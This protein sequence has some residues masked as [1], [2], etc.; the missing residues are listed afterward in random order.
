LIHIQKAAAE[1][2]CGVLGGRSLTMLLDAP[3]AARLEGW[4]HAAFLDV[5]YGSLR[6]LGELRACLAELLRRPLQPGVVESLLLVA[7]YQ[8]RYSRAAAHAVVD[9]A[10][11]C[12]AAIGAP[13]AKGLV[14]AVLRAFLMDPDGIVARAHSTEEGKFSHPSWWI[15]KLR[16]QYPA[17]WSA[18]LAAGNEHPPLTLRVRVTRIS[19]E[20]YLDR[21]RADRIEARQTGVS[22][23]TLERPL[24]VAAVPGFA[25]GL[26]SVQDAGA[27]LAAPLLDLKDGMRVLDACAAPGGKSSHILDLARV[28]LL[29]LDRDEPRLQKVRGN[30]DRLGL[31]AEVVTGDAAAPATWWDGTPFHRILAD[32]PCSASGVVRR[33]PDVKWLRRP[34]DVLGFAANQL[35][36][37]D[38]LWHTLRR[39]GKLLY[40]TCSVFREENQDQADRFLS[41]HRD[42][43]RLPVAALPEDGMLLPNHDHDGFF[44]ALF[45]KD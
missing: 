17:A 16:L 21:L 10:V 34:A 42:A 24:P 8:L 9:H 2:L 15:N 14:N 32:V 13:R 41:R 38:A 12:A 30:L 43:R 36:L 19:L 35:A 23:V 33:H 6:Y 44:Y 4:A 37:L 27:Q 45:E 31:A 25:A 28:R 39:G 22:A 11:D 18:V 29:A 7:L 40:V 1:T 3:R 5:I 20:R 26:V